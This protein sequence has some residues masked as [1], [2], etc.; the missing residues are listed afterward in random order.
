MYNWDKNEMTEPKQIK[1]AI[2]SCS[3]N[4]IKKTSE[5]LKSV[6]SQKVSTEYSIVIYLLDDNSSDGTVDFVES[7]F[8]SVEILRGSGSLFWAGG[9][10][11]LWEQ[12]MKKDEYD[13]F[14]LFND[15]VV[16][17]D[18]ALDRLLAAYYLS[19]Y[20]ENII[21]GT[22]QDTEKRNITYGGQK[23]NNRLTGNAVT[24]E[25]DAVSLK[26]CEIGN[27]NIMLVDK[28][29]VKKIGIL[30][31]SFTHGIA[32]YDYTL[33]AVENGLK[34]WVAP[35]YYGCCD[36]DHGVSW[37]SQ[38]TPLKKRIEYLYSP[39]GLAYKQHLLYIKKHFPLS[40][41]ISYFKFWVKTLFP[42]IYDVFKKEKGKVN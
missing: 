1:L 12:V 24:L 18:G 33:T 29:T 32:D 28:A 27:A 20:T 25:P 42:F 23:I 8:P 41:P 30:S 13:F 31:G 36:N 7:H 19:D 10:R 16:L 11:T 6:V 21:L 17:F 40:L 39:K 38:G 5:F 4:R 34:V 15:D 26:P 9:M 35:G 37:L 2:L 22:V 14:L 3:Y